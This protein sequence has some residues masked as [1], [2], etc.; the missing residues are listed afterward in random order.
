MLIFQLPFGTALRVA[1][2]IDM[3]Q[4]IFAHLA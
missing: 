1:K 4:Q 3:A 2:G